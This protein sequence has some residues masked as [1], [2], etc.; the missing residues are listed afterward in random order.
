MYTTTSTI[1][2]GHFYPAHTQHTQNRISSKVCAGVLGVLGKM[3]NEKFSKLMNSLFVNYLI[4]LPKITGGFCPA[5]SAQQHKPYRIHDFDCAGCVLG[6]L[7]S[8]SVVK[9]C[10][11]LTLIAPK[12][13]VFL[14]STPS[15]PAQTLSDTR[16]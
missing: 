12:N 13:Q 3:V 6:D 2:A 4:L 8:T 7:P 5:H 9:R 15:T 1:C 14:T 16:F 10:V 11:S